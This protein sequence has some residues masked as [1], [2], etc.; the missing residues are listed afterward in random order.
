MS[1]VGFALKMFGLAA[2]FLVALTVSFYPANLWLPFHE[3]FPSFLTDESFW[4]I[5]GKSYN[6]ILSVLILGVMITIINMAWRLF[7]D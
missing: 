6:F 5:V 1:Q 3:F 4:Q 2:V 7:E